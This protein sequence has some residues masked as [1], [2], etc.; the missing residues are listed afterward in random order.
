MSAMNPPRPSTNRL[1][2]IL[3]AVVALI[4]L[5]GGGLLLMSRKPIPNPAASLA[6][7]VID[8]A[9]D[10]GE[11]QPTEAP[12]V[13][14]FDKPMDK[15][16]VE[17]AFDIS[18]KVPG[19]FKWSADSKSVQFVPT[20][21]GFARGTTYNVKLLDTAKAVNG[22]TLGQLLTFAFKAVG[23]LNVTQVIPADN[24]TDIDPAADI[25]VMFNRPVV[26]LL[27]ASDQTKLPQPLTFDPVIKGTG[28]WLNTSIYVFHPSERLQAGVQYT[29]K[30]A[31][32]LQDPTGAV[33]QKD[34][35]WSF[36]TQTPIVIRNAPNDS[37]NDVDLDQ[38]LQVTFNQPMD[39]ASVQAAFALHAGSI[40]GGKV[41][42]TFTWLTETVYIPTAVGQAGKLTAP[43]LGGRG[44]GGQSTTLLG[45][46]MVFTS[47]QLLERGTQYF[48]VVVAG[49]KAKGGGA[50]M[51]ADYS[52]S[53]KTVPVF[54]VIRTDPADGSNN[55]APYSAV[56]IY[57]S[58]P[59]KESTLAN[60]TV[61]PA[62]ISASLVYTYY[63]EYDHRYTFGFAAA[64]SSDFEVTIGADVADK[65]G[66]SLGEARSI[67]FSTR[68]LDP[69]Q[70][71]DVQGRFGTYSAYTDTVVYARY[72]NVTQL[73]FELYQVDLNTFAQLIGNDSYNLWNSSV[74]VRGAPI[75][76][77]SVPVTPELNKSGL[78]RVPIGGETGGALT[79]GIYLVRVTSP[80]QQQLDFGG[81]TRHLIV[82]ANTNVTF[83]SAEREGLV[84]ATDLQSGDVTTGAPISI[85]DSTFKMLANGQTDSSGLFQTEWQS[86][87]NPFDTTAVVVGEP[88]GTFGIAINTWTDG[89]GP[90]DFGVNANYFNDPYNVYI[91]TEKPLYRPGQ[92]VHF[93]G[94]VRL[95]DDARYA[96][97]PNLRSIDVIV[98]DSQGNQVLS[99]TLPVSEYGSFNADLKL[100]QAAGL[101]YYSIQS[102]V[103]MV[104][105]NVTGPEVHTYYGQFL[106]S[107]Y[108]RP[109]FQ[110]NVTTDKP[111]VLQGATVNVDVEAKY[112]FGGSV[113]GADVSWT[114]LSNNYYFDRYHG[115][116][117]FNW[118]DTDYFVG[119]QQARSGPLA[120]GEGKTD[121]SGHFKIT[122]PAK[123]DEKSGSQTFSVEASITDLNGQQV[124][125]RVTVIVHQGS[126][127]IGLAPQE[128][129]G[130]VG[131]PLGFDLRSVDWQGDPSGQRNIDVIFYQR[132]WFNVQETDDFGN[133]FW[134]YSF[135][136]T[137]IFK[138]ST[139]TTEG[140]EGTVS[141][142]PSIGGEYHVVATGKDENGNS[143]RSA[144]EVWV[145]SQDYISWRQENND[146]IQLVADKKAY[147]PGDTAKIL[148]PSPYQGKVKALVTVER[149]RILTS[150]VI[151]LQTNSDVIEVPIT[152]D[153][154]PNAFVSVVIVKGID[155]SNLA[156]S[157][158]MGYAS[159]TVNRLQQLLNITLTPDR[160]PS[161]SH[162]GP[163][164]PIS[165]TIKVT[166]FSGKPVQSEV[167]LALVD[168]SVLSLADPLERPIAD[169]YYG[170]RG[171]GVSTSTSLVYSVDRI[172][173]KLALEA[174]GGGG[175]ASAEGGDFFIRGNFPD[176]AYWNATVTTDAN[177]EATISTV[178][179]DNLT[180]WRLLAKAVSKNTLVGEGQ[181]DVLSTKDL[182]V[183]PVTPRFFIVGDK[184]NLAAVVHNNT[185][186]D[187]TVDVSMEGT[188]ISVDNGQI[189][190]TVQ[191]KANDKVRVEW[192]TTIKDASKAD[193]TFTARA[194]TGNLSDAT[195]PTA[196]LPPDQHLPIYKFSTPETT[197]TAGTVD[198]N[199]V[200][201]EVVALPQRLDV[202]QGDLT[203]KID[204]SLAAASTDG[205]DY[206]EH[207]PYECTEQTV[208][209]FLPNVLTY[210][211]LKELNLND[212]KLEAN[213]KE[214][215]GTAL[216]R[217]NAQQHADGGWGWWIDD[218]S[219]PTV[220]T[221]VVLGLV[222]AKQ[223]GFA[224]D[225][226][227]ID[228][229]VNYLS[230]QLIPTTQLQE[231]WKVNRQAYILY[232]MAEAG[233][234]DSSALVSLYDGKRQ[235]LSNYGKAL[236]A[237]AF[238]LDKANQQSRMATLMSDLQNSAKVSATGQHWEETAPDWFSWN[239]DTRSTA[240]VLDAFAQ[241]DPKNALAPNVVR[242]LMIARTAG[243]WETTQET[244]WSLIALTDWMKT[245]GELRP[246]YNWKVTV[247]DQ[248]IGSGTANTDTVKVSN[249]LTEAVASLLRD[250]GNALTI[251]RTASSGQSGNGQLYYSAY[252]RAFIPVADVKSLARG[253][254]IARQ[255]FA[256]DDACYKPLLPD[257][258]P[259]DCTPVKQAKVGDT[260]IVK[261]SIIA[262]TDLVYVLIE[263]PLPAGTEAVDTSLKTTSQLGQ[264]PEL[265]QT[266]YSAFGGWGWWWFTHSELRDEKV[267]LFATNLP[268]GTYEYTYQIRAGIDGTFNVLPAH[269][270][271]MYFPE[272]FGRSDGSQF[273]VTK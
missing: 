27:A 83:K 204:P 109:Q 223:A 198:K 99:S 163:R 126:Y 42:G 95:D 201:I 207:F 57:F 116:G 50:P 64:P 62:P 113:N 190:Q 122:L 168:L 261:L 242:W 12:I 19:A 49:A 150:R 180:T 159:F 158:K 96:I 195:K 28:E 88:G 272:V 146:R 81:I 253:I 119:P 270:E 176:T 110:V 264:S 46:T 153:M 226:N 38:A 108:V 2:L 196:G 56:D 246:D 200:R 155:Q 118:N 43:A 167:S 132:E 111:E 87:V 5:V 192:P 216:Q 185:A 69:E 89:I 147:A 249:T 40:D 194:S 273:I 237:L 82:V 164:D 247:N 21:D 124:S 243:H 129:V 259:I 157:F 263:D 112:F 102:Q 127:Y 29:A 156:P 219:D 60:I 197:A 183:E 48:A 208:S 215:V 16:S 172:N 23:F 1:P 14:N 45:E 86:S 181:S 33:L 225:Q 171:L 169:Q 8:R 188:G 231:T 76:A 17:A 51:S 206:L 121:A 107:E 232:V 75:R 217:L 41:D 240:I 84:W 218:P 135:S 11:E 10:R 59:V 7:I 6:P 235:L 34:Y 52:W 47:S 205:L 154:A 251:E 271:E 80:E 173:A 260:L 162:Y 32:G 85:Y 241:I 37:Q 55:V 166:D 224:V 145:S 25:T 229:G 9:P 44:G 24:S 250:Q 63:S 97:D 115:Q 139:T 136:D 26:P 20:G 142:V 128:Y 161:K 61:S 170:E 91:Y 74:P 100:D 254:V 239:T 221:Y 67:R 104:R 35:S 189:K 236:M 78:L 106:V 143:I 165:Y 105:P 58:G 179:P 125:G 258:K 211:A 149:G 252:L 269:A 77:W 141:F 92:T 193:L 266:D 248:V 191:V 98:Y 212:P 131:K 174:K 117:Y 209:R 123:L 227:V 262:P 53:F 244:A 15:P 230:G 213:L 187:L 268:A 120:S 134:T 140:G 54:R 13:L 66:Q 22:K 184:V 144:T 178:L 257:Q 68:A 130:V 39:H 90:W 228:R 199:D 214:Q 36:T 73:D 3:I 255:Y 30:V 138:T 238:N 148:I 177:G 31:K 93:R 72:R 203:V 18:P 256:S 175:G 220:S 160:D 233:K 210:R 182:L 94:L 265:N 137:E 114:A 151:D 79:T 71:F 103:P 101:G 186:N 70:W 234:G 4:V 133:I 202:T 245:T 152:P 65:W 222:K 267:A